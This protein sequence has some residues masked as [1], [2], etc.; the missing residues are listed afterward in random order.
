MHFIRYSPLIV[1]LVFMC[2]IIV[3]KARNQMHLRKKAMLAAWLTSI[4]MATATKNIEMF[5]ARDKNGV[6]VTL[7]W[8][9]TS[10]LSP[11]FAASMKNIW[12]I[13]R[14][15]YTPV[16]M[17]FLRAFPDVVQQEAYFKPFEK[18]FAQAI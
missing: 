15:A 10:I 18:L 11:D 5:T 9:K 2:S 12:N 7:E 6:S 16:E 1:I 17:Q 4:S 14:Q 8:Q 13:A 3:Y